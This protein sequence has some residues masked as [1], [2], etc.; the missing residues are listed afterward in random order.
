[1][2]PFLQR[3][4]QLKD[5]MIATRRV[6]HQNAGVGFDLRENADLIMSRLRDMGLEPREICPCGI[7]AT[8][9]S[10]GSGKK[11]VLL[12]AD[13]DALPLNE[14]SGLP[15]AATNGTC[16]ACGHDFNAV[17]LLY[18]AKMLKEREQE[19][20][21][22]VKL[23]FQPAEEIGKGAKAMIDAGLLEDP[24]V[25]VA[26][27]LH[28]GVG[29]DDCALGDVRY[30]RGP[31]FA[32]CDRIEITVKGKGGHGA[33]PFNGIDP[34]T[35]AA[36][37]LLGLQNIIPMEINP[38][39]RAI[40][41]FG[42][43]HAGSAANA[44]PGEAVLAGTLRTTDEDVRVFMRGRIREI[45][46]NIAQA[47]RCRAE[48]NLDASSIPLCVMDPALGDAARP[49]IDEIRSGSVF[50]SNEMKAM[51]SEDFAEVCSRVPGMVV[52]IGAGSPKEGYTTPVHNPAVLFNEDCL[53]QGAAM[54]AN[55]AFSWLRDNNS[56]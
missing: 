17:S 15:F 11:T 24:P 12:R 37:I 6:I 9:G 1:M 55:L 21:G 20:A 28:M 45:A 56:Q 16:H 39:R 3:A 27:G 14:E 22:T 43:F 53:V 51:G 23:M 38:A 10:G 50:V 19:L 49:Y 41:A 35:A 31:C 25:D 54:F 32:A 13:Y 18:A 42:S 40:L 44:I 46:E 8:I 2:N 5:E 52:G 26:F 34:I 48:V 47:M 33:F 4:A 30:T 36:R 29:A 7:V